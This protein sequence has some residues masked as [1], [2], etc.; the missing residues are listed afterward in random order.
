[1]QRSSATLWSAAT[2]AAL[3]LASMATPP[4]A[5]QAQFDDVG[6][7]TFPTSATGEAQ[8]P[9]PA[10]RRDPAQLRLEAGARAVP[11]GPGDRPRLRNGVLGRV[12]RVQSPARHQDGPR[13]SPG[14]RS[15][16]SRKTPEERIAKAPDRAREGASC[17]PSRSSG[18]KASTRDQRGF[19]LHGSD[20]RPSRGLSRTT[21]KSR[22]STRCRS[23]A[24][25]ALT[26][27]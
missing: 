14:R 9:L 10:R 15:S 24:S 7:I 16:A 17:A 5:A 4:P 23:W 22:P 8:E 20:G 18:A 12:A 27:T 1:M 2:A 11:R 6:V 26:R 13:P 21:T 25:I 19:E 3:I